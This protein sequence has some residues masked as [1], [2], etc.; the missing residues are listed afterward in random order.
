M[1]Y[2]YQVFV[3][4]YPSSVIVGVQR[5]FSPCIA[6]LAISRIFDS[7]ITAGYTSAGMSWDMC[8]RLG[9]RVIS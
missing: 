5:S 4:L 8:K 1:K 9:R 6:V 3:Q 7:Q 2:A